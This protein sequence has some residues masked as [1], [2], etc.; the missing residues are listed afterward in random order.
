MKMIRR[1]FCRHTW[2]KA[3]RVPFETD[4]VVVRRCSKDCGKYRVEPRPVSNVK[5][6][7]WRVDV[8]DARSLFSSTQACT[9]KA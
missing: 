7:S 1:L 6:R 4:F 9:R 2:S 8:L 5:A 3:E